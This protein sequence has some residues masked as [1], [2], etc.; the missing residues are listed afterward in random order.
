MRRATL[1]RIVKDS[2][3]SRQSRGFTLIELGVVVTIIGILAVIAVVAY[4]KMILSS[5]VTEAETMINAIRLAEENYKAESGV[6]LD[7]SAAYCPS[8]GMQ[9]KKWAWDNPACASNKWAQLPVHA[10]GPVQF[11]YKV[12][13]GN[14]TN[15]QQYGLP[16][17]LIDVSG[18]TSSKAPHYIV[19]AQADLNADGAPYTQLAGSSFTGHIYRLNEGD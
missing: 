17:A 9:Q 4:R 18:L 11:G 19:H 13:A 14:G 15:V 7:I 12:F 6:Y 16:T 2:S 3:R 5:K 10:D 8:D 1:A